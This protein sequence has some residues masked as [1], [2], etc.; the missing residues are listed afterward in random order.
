MANN[1]E[2]ENYKFPELLLAIYQTTW[3]NIPEEC[4]LSI[5]PLVGLSSQSPNQVPMTFKT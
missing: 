1:P 2:N 5:V 4:C 3:H